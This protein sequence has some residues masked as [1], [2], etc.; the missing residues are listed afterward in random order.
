MLARAALLHDIG[1]TGVDNHIL[2]SSERFSANQK[3]EL[4]ENHVRV[5]FEALKEHDEKLARIV[6]GHHEHQDD[7]YPRQTK[8]EGDEK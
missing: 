7:S 3:R 1:K 4:M 8:R 5:A 2:E 6:V